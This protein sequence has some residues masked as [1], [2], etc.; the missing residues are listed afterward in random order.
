MV[1]N[2]FC[3]KK[4][5]DSSIDDKGIQELFDIVKNKQREDN[6]KVFIISHRSELKNYD[7]IDQEYFVVKKNGYSEVIIK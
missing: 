6:S 2:T 3:L 5:L 4:L 1:F 7:E